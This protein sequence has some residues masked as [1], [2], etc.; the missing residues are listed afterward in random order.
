M[1]K[2]TIVGYPR[3]GVQRELKFAVES[4]FKKQIN[5]KDLEAIAK[6]LREGYLK[7][8]KESGIDIIPSNDFSFYDNLL[9]TAFLLN[10]IPSRYTELGL[11]K[12]ETYF[13]MARGYQEGEND[14]KAL[15]MKKWFNTN[16]HYIVPELNDDAKIK[17]NDDKP[18]KL[19]KEADKLGINTKPVLIGPFTLIKL[20]NI[21]G[22]KNIN[23]WITP[24]VNAY[25][26]ILN[27]FNGQGLEYLQLDEPILVTDLNK[28]D[29]EIYNKIYKELLEKKNDY[30]IILQTYFGNVSDIYEDL[31][32][33]DFD[34]YAFDFIE[35][36]KNI[37]LIKKFGFPKEK[38]LFA[39][40]VNGK[41]IWRNNY[42]KSIEI[43][44]ELKEY[45]IEGNIYISTSC[46]LLHVPY[47][48]K[49]EKDL[50]D[51]YK[52]TLAFAQEK[53]GELAELKK[54]V[55]D[56]NYEVDN[57]FIDNQ[58]IINEKL[59]N[60][61][62]F[63]KEVRERVASLTDADFTRTEDFDTRRELQ[64]VELNLPIL[65]TTTIGSF[66]QTIE[67]KR[68]R[69]AFKD[70]E[71]SKEEYENKLKEKTKEI[72]EF[73]EEIGLD[74]LVHGEYERT[75]MVEYFGRLLDGFIFTSNGWVQSYGTRGVKPPVIFGDV[76]RSQDLT[77]GWSKFAKGLTDKVVKG[78]LTGPI[79]I[80][81]WSFPREDLDLKNISYQ[82]GLAI[83]DEVLELEKNGIKVIQID[84]AALREKLP[85]RKADWNSEYLDFAIPAF[86]LTNSKVKADTSIHTHMCYSEFGDIIKA[87]ED[88]DADVISIEA[89]RSDF[90]LLDFLRES[91]F[92]LEIGPGVYDIHSPRVPSVIEIEGLIKV[93]ISKLD[94]DKIW[95]N[96]DCG[97]KT[98][99]IKETKES[100][101]N[102]VE[103]TKNIRKEFC[104]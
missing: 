96:P 13:A 12:L 49:N 50:A 103:A 4:Y 67:I 30:K 88:M 55:N 59:V 56:K 71:I 20:T 70:G 10:I 60:E 102:L 2:S 31:I 90:S 19:Y 81:N 54:L 14:V 22:G 48:V 78:M 9:D 92:K 26:E 65:P 52:K 68:Y 74:V 83:G 62:C 58:K 99:G 41:N 45:I 39:G 47:T 87:I 89:A 100:L 38:L 6:D 72:I 91:E 15:P 77:V 79:T 61:I 29:I 73:Q 23:D 86:R 25:K 95:I 85:L 63:N 51:E 97:L 98:R 21:K 11:S 16:Y 75:D 66:P 7:T 35:G 27:K 84:E 1:T 40:V 93:I 80:L 17:L 34:G 18:F 33:L 46:S 8:Q 104:Q 69:K 94:I 5:E 32:K 53:L 43:V 44:S 28:D 101:I 42:K 82:I 64:S 57:I 76:K 24:L 36:Y 3:I 37:D